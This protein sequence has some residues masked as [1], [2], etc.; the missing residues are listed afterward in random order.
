VL[1]LEDMRIIMESQQLHVCTLTS[2]PERKHGRSK[3][4]GDDIDDKVQL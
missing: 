2:L 4:V 3:L 1:V